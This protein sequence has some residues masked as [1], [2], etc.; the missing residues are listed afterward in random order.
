[1]SGLNPLSLTL[2]LPFLTQYS[3]KPRVQISFPE[4]SPYTKQSF[5][6]ECDINTIMARYQATGQLPEMDVRAPQ[7]LDVTGVEFQSSMEFIAGAKTIF[8][9]LPSHLRSRFENEPAKFLDFCS[10]P[11]NRPEMADLGLLS[12]SATLD[13]QNHRRDMETAL[14][15]VKAASKPSVE[16]PADPAAQPKTD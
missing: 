7:Y 2:K 15:A 12:A 13:V 10:D 11:K 5:K 3:I 1:M 9:E 8:E 6:D 16:K 4:D 14:E